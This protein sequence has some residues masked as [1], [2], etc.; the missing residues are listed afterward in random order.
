MSKD[1]NHS[2]ILLKRNGIHQSQRYI[3]ALDP[4]SV[5]LHDLSIEDWMVFAHDF[6]GSVNY[7]GTKTNN[8]EGDWTPF[9]HEKDVIKNLLAKAE[10]DKDLT[11]HLSL[12]VCFLKLIEL[13][14]N[15]LNKLSKRHLDFY[16]KE[17]LKLSHKEAVADKV[18]LLFELAK[19]ASDVRVAVETKVDAGKDGDGNKRIY[20]TE[21]ELIVNSAK[22]AALKNVFHD[23]GSGVTYSEVAN[24]FDGL[25]GDFPNDIV[26]FWPFGHP[27]FDE[28]NTFPNLPNA[29]LGFAIASPILLLKEGKRTITFTINF[30]KQL[31]VT[32]SDTLSDNT[33][34]VLL[35]GEKEWIS[36]AIDLNLSSAKNKQLILFVKLSEAI[37]AV[38]PYD[39]DVLLENFNSTNP[40]AR[41]IF[42]TGEDTSGYQFYKL[43]N[44][45][46]V[47]SIKIDVDV[48]EMQELI[49]ENDLGKLDASKPFLP[50]GPL[51]VRDSK[52]YIGCQE[53][54]NKPWSEVI[55]NLSWKDTPPTLKAGD[56]PFKEHYIAYRTNHL[57][58]LGK[59]NYGLTTET[60]RDETNLIVSSSEYF[61]VSI[62]TLSNKSWDL[63]S[64]SEALFIKND[65]DYISSFSIEPLT[66]IERV[67]QKVVPQLSSNETAAEQIAKV[68]KSHGNFFYVDYLNVF[69]NSSF[70]F[71]NPISEGIGGTFDNPIQQENFSSNAKRGFIRLSLQ[72]SF[73]HK[74]F[75]RIYA[76]ALSID[77]NDKALIPN[78]PYTPLAETIMVDYKASV[79]KNFNLNDDT[80]SLKDNLTNYLDESLELFHEHPFGQSEQHTYLKSKHDFLSSKACRLVPNYENGTLFI[81]LEKAEQLQQVS[82]LVQVLEGS[83]NPEYEGE[84]TF[85]GDEKLDWYI[86]SDDEWKPLNDNYIVS[87]GTDNFLK[88][89]IVKVS[90]PKE[91]T[92]NN[93][94]ISGDVFWL[95][96]HN[97][98]K[99]DT[100]CQL[101]NIHTQA[102]LAAFFDTNN[103][104]SHLQTGLPEETIS[105]LVERVATLKGVRQPYSSFGGV[106]KETDSQFYRRISERLR[107]KQRAIT[108]WDY[109]HTILQQFPNIYKVNCL[110]HTIGTSELS[111]GHVTI[112][113][114]PNIIN[115]NVFDRYKPRISKANRNAIQ[116]FINQLN[117]LHVDALVENPTYQEV[118][119]QLEVKFYE[120]KDKSFYSKQLKE[121][122]V[123]FLSPWAYVETAEINFGLTLHESTVIY[124]IEQLSYVDYVK[125][126]ELQL[127][128]KKKDNEGNIIYERVKSVI[129]ANSK[130][131]L[132]SVKMEEHSVTPI[133]I[134]ECIEA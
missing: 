39:K 44:E 120:G 31:P 91:A 81:G 102:D 5:K 54:L 77:S 66:A 47:T 38:V 52:L 14:Q 50:F 121:D 48:K 33:I 25:G 53:A 92:K 127:E 83:E 64:R 37:D 97:V 113:V 27:D 131:I 11:P 61:K 6:A 7:F 40:I 34:S 17:V 24:S 20:K 73:L 19:N 130:V 84:N 89:G 86:L 70:V 90:I 79:T 26:K 126:F 16:Y 55:V 58:N 8:V 93:N 18:H 35:S 124:Y 3:D 74:L 103:E 100:V 12:F 49:L 110:K 1:C 4:N 75:P 22:I 129:P 9:F 119:V 51:P 133:D 87:N 115:L 63:N 60:P 117:T 101:V 82:L 28:T 36:A 76:V 67:K 72:Q 114:V 71:Q 46:T 21:N 23:N 125:N 128:T 30:E 85:E 112:I 104:L 132:T 94:R 13:S 68:G 95:K 134:V 106:P 122:V 105:K 80:E 59:D 111:P 123:K 32:L 29:K 99:F 57:A 45:A 2:D 107:H 88:S 43:L 96:V 42:K 56:D 65:N 62:E 69:N 108:I 118:K 98:K 41:F 10:V 116:T 15:R 78:E 109:E